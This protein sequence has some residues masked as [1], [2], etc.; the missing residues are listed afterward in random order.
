MSKMSKKGYFAAMQK[1]C[2]SAVGTVVHNFK[3]YF[4][5]SDVEGLGSVSQRF[6][7]G[8]P[9][10]HPLKKQMKGKETMFKKMIFERGYRTNLHQ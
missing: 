4:S 6:G 1:V 8:K 7:S 10:H 9:L 2:H 3:I 5:L